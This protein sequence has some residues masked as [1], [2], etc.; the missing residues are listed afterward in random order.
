M[1]YTDTHVYVADLPQ[2]TL[3]AA[4]LAQR[5]VDHWK[6]LAEFLV[7]LLLEIARTHVVNHR[8]LH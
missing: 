8:R 6:L 3:E 1:S 5:Q 2:I 4:Q 7:E